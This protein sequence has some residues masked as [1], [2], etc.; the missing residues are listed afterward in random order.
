MGRESGHGLAGSYALGLTGCCLDVGHAVLSSGISLGSSLAE[1][2]S[3]WLWDWVMC[4]YRL[5]SFIGNSW[6]FALHCCRVSFL[7]SPI[8][9]RAFT[10][11]NRTPRIIFLLI[12]WCETLIISEKFLHLCRSR[13]QNLVRNVMFH[14]IRRF[15]PHSDSG[16]HQMCVHQGA[17]ILRIV[18]EFCLLH[19]LWLKVRS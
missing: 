18:L 13:K 8:F 14:P 11:L 16:L 19:M 12:N 15:G 7:D 10:W 5:P 3:L 1:F 6:Q 2:S 17:R 4:S 9:L